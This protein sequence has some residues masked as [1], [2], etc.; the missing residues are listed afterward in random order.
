MYGPGITINAST[1]LVQ[2]QFGEHT[3]LAK[4]IEGRYPAWQSIVP[5]D[6]AGSV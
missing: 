1:A 6:D 4:L 2:F 5:A 3:I